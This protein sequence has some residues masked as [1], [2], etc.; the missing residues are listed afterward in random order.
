MDFG[1]ARLDEG[2]EKAPHR[3]LDVELPMAMKKLACGDTR[4]ELPDLVK[5]VG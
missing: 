5:L 4:W 2:L 1:L 3:L